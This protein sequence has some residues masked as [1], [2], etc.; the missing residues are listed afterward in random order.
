MLLSIALHFMKICMA[1]IDTELAL[2][3]DSKAYLLYYISDGLLE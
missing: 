1:L 3:I 2:F